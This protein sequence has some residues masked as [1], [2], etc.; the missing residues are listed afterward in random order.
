MP[1]T[2][3]GVNLEP[4]SPVAAN[5]VRDGSGNFT[6]SFYRRSRLS[7]SW[8]STG[9]PAPVGETTEAYEIDVMSGSTVKRTIS[10]STPTFSYSAADQTTDFGSVQA[11]ITFRI[12]QL[13]EIVGRGYHLEVTL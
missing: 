12:Y 7:S 3:E 1:F 6:G 13:S 9:V 5:G 11:S 8:W 2:Y 10:V 4:L